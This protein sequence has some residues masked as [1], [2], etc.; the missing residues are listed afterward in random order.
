MLI[1]VFAAQLL[2]SIFALA[3]QVEIL[4]FFEK[5]MMK[6]L[7]ALSPPIA[8]GFDELQ[9]NLACCGVANASDWSQSAIWVNQSLAIIQERID[10][11]STT[12]HFRR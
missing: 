3:Y 4:P 10:I 6:A 5:G 12:T 11:V 1:I 8:L 7:E 9:H 2:L